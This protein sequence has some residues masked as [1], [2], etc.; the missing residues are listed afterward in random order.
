MT[1]NIS[2]FGT[3]STI[4]ASNTFP[5]P[6]PLTFYA[7][8]VDGLDFAERQI[9]DTKNGPNGQMVSWSVSNAIEISVSPIVGSPDDIL[10]A[11]IYNANA[12][13]PN[14]TS[15]RDVIEMT[16]LSPDLL[17]SIGLTDGV[18][19]SATAGKG[20]SSSGRQKTRTYK[21]RFENSSGGL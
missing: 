15:A 2:G 4:V 5:L 9:A 3:V 12:T 20:L 11:T 10:L 21:F 17:S 19:I 13:G 16:V 14:K 1:I 8:D 18:M 6:A 7:D